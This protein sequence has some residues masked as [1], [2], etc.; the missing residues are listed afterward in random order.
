MS[1]IRKPVAPP[2]QVHRSK[3]DYKRKPKHPN[4][5]EEY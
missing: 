3:K 4:Q 2:K 1:K 5:E